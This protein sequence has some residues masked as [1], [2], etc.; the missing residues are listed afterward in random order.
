MS[1]KTEDILDDTNR[2][3]KKAKEKASD[4]ISDATK[5]AEKMIEEGRKKVESLVK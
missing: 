5:A 2:L 3:I 1:D 4:I